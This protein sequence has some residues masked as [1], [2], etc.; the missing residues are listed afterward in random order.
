MSLT[1]KNATLLRDLE[2]SG[3][4][5]ELLVTNQTAVIVYMRDVQTEER[6]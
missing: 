2:T 4:G 1:P 6:A 5:F 3:G